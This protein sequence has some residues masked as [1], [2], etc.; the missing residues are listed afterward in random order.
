MKPNT[1]LCW[2]CWIVTLSLLASLVIATGSNAAETL[3]AGL[4]VVS[5]EARPTAIELKHKFDNRQVLVLG[6]LDSGEVVDMTRIVKQSLSGDVAIATP[7]GNVRAN[8]DGS[9]ELAFTHE[10]LSVKVPITVAGTGDKKE[11]SFVQDVQPVLS[12]AGC[13]QGT[14]H[15]SKEGKNGF[16]LSLRGYDPIYDYRAITDDIGARRFN[17]ANPDQSLFLLKTTGSAPHV[18]GVR[19]NYGDPYY[20]MLREW[21]SQGVKLDLA[22]PRV[23]KIEIF[24]TDTIIPRAGMKQQIVVNAHYADGTIRDVTREAFIESGNIEVLEAAPTGIV[25]TLRR[26]EAPVLVRYEGSY[27]AATLIVMGDRSGFQWKETPT[28]NYLDEL[29]YKKLQRVKILPSE[30]CSDDEFIRRVTIDLTGLPPTVEEVRAFLADTRDTRTK[31][32]EL[33]DRLVGSRAYVEH[34]TNKWADLLQVNRKFLGEEGSLALRNWIKD[35]VASNKPYDQFAR[36]VLTAAGSNLENPPA[37]YYKVIRD[38]ESLM[39]NTTHLFLAVRF[40][41]NKCHDHPFE[42]WTQDQ[43]YHLAAYFAQVGRKPDQNFAGQNIG[44]SAVEGAVPLVEVIY[45]TGSGEVTHNRTG[46]QSPPLFPY[47]QQLVNAETGTARD[48][49]WPSG[50]RRR[51]TSTSPRAT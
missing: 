12:K 18:G 48:S 40:N 30:L 34:W 46:K 36:E 35:A 23:T 29:V 33:V 45:D 38:P 44:G 13:N 27:A 47:Q 43:Y 17:R 25:T 19:M 24:P 26:G 5:L 51:I 15:G 2:L 8:K 1:P 31:R 22:K 6:K 37:S 14:C 9:A 11:V 41:C 10:N 49:N 50:S 3:P 32:D 16:K 42:R 4:K 21:V 7:E 28:H 39:E 20:N